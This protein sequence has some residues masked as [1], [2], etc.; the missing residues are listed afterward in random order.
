M[1]SRPFLTWEFFRLSSFQ[2]SLTVLRNTRQVFCRMSLSM[3]VW[4]FFS[5]WWYWV[6]RFYRED[7]RG[8]VPFSSHPIKGA[9]CQHDSSSLVLTLIIWLRLYLSGF[10]TVMVLFSYDTQLTLKDAELSTPFLGGNSYINYLEFFS[11]GD[12]SL[13][14]KFI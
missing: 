13:L 11:Q 12:S 10:S 6:M 8:K 9:C 2:V 3:L 5:S 14:L 4:C 1:S 7:P